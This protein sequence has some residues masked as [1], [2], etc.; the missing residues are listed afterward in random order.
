MNRA[1]E[2]GDAMVVKVLGPGC[3]NCMTLARRTEEALEQLNID[4]RV[5]KVTD[6]PAILSYGVL[7]TPGLVI[8]GAVVSQ[9]RVP[10]LDA[11]K[12]LIRN[13]RR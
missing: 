12:E 8:D 3:M 9:G 4:A 10:T 5:E 7:S 11:I 6:Y 13:A 1:A 2:K